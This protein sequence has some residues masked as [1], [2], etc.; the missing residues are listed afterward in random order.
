MTGVEERL[1]SIENEVKH[2][3]LALEKIWNKLDELCPMVK[4]NNWWVQ[5]IKRSVVT[6]AVSGV[7]GGLVTTGYFLIRSK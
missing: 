5:S 7:L 6:L 2:S 1:A 4:E 3:S